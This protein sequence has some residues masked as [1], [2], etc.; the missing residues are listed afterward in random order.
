MAVVATRGYA[1]FGGG[2]GGSTETGPL[3]KNFDLE[4]IAAQGEQ[5][6]RLQEQ[7]QRGRMQEQAA[8]FGADNYKTDVNNATTRFGMG[9]DAETARRGQDINFALGNRGYDVTQEGNRMTADVAREGQQLGAETTRRGQDLQFQASMAPIN[10]ARERFNSVFPVFQQ[11]L[12]GGF[13]SERVG[14]TNTPTPGITVGGVYSPQQIDQQVNAAKASSA[15]DAA[16]QKRMVEQ[17]AGARGMSSRS[18]LVAALSG[19]IDAARM[20]GDAD[21]ERGIRFDAAGANAKQQLA[22]E[23]Q[24]ANVWAQNNQLDINRRQAIANQ[25]NQLLAALAG[26]I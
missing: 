20:V 1:S 22:T 23:T 9:L 6:R 5:D 25:Q 19:G 7:Q 16:T 8:A 17:Q 26:I 4:N 11:A 13:G 15:S 14:G 18:P 10:W 21:A 3:Y 2:P 12:E 24:R